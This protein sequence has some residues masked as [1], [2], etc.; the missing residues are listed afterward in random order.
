MAQTTRNTY[1]KITNFITQNEKGEKRSGIEEWRGMAEWRNGGIAELDS[2]HRSR[3][4]S[5]TEHKSKAE[6][7]QNQ[8]KQ[9]MRVMK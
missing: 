1:S 9:E 2:A 4:R 3:I 6:G 7:K 5:G 8:L